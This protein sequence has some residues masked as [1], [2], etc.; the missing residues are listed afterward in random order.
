MC[1]DCGNTWPEEKKIPV[2]KKFSIKVYD[3]LNHL[4]EQ[5]KTNE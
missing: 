5:D 1:A 3:L 4:D 2:C